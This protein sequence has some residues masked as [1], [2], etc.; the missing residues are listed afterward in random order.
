MPMNN[1][2]NG[3]GC[4]T[5]TMDKMMCGGKIC[6][7]SYNHLIKLIL[8]LFI[9]MMVFCFGFLGLLVFGF[10]VFGYIVILKFRSFLSI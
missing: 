3:C 2:N 8:M 6:N 4:S 1:H 7:H 10:I 9:L 5:C